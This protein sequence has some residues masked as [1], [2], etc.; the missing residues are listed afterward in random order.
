MVRFKGKLVEII[1][2]GSIFI[3][4]VFGRQTIIVTIFLALDML[5]GDLFK[6]KNFFY[7]PF[8]QRIFIKN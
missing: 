1:F 6:H 7:F 5:Y 4:F 2:K 3:R 8:S